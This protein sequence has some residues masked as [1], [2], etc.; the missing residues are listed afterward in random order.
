MGP[1][2]A[3]II[4]GV[5]DTP[6]WTTSLMLAV[7]HAALALVF[8]IY[9]LILVTEAG[10]NA[11]DAEQVVTASILAMAAGTLLQALGWRQMGSGYLAVQ[12]NN[13]IYLP[14][15]ILAVHAGGLDTAF[16]MTIFAGAAA[17][18]FSRAIKHLRPFFPAEVCGVGVLMLGISM[19][20][21][22]SARFSG[23]TETGTFDAGV[24]AV[25]S[26]TF[27]LMVALSVWPKGRV[28]LYSAIIGLCSGYAASIAFGLTSM[29][30][31]AGIMDRGLLA[32]PR[33]QE[34]TP[35]FSPILAVPFLLTAMVSTLDSMA[36]L[37]TCQKINHPAQSRPDMGNIGQGILADGCGTI[38]AGLFGT[39]GTGVSSAHIALTSATGA[40]SRTIGIWTSATLLATAFVPPVAK[41]LAR[42]PDPVIGAVMAYASAFLITSGME[43]IVSRILDVRR[44]FMVGCSVIVG[45]SSL[46]SGAHATGI[47]EWAASIVSSPFA[48]ASLCAVLL[49]SLF[50][51]GTSQRASL[52]IGASTESIGPLLRFLDAQCAAWGIRRQVFFQL[53]ACAT[54][55]VELLILMQSAEGPVNIEARSEEHGLELAIAYAGAPL[56]LEPGSPDPEEFLSSKAAAARLAGALV[57]QYADGVSI[58]SRQGRQRIK[59]HFEP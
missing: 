5:S 50:R 1:K 38:C 12:I 58:E 16:G 14:V 30:E 18:L 57:R 43:L 25:A 22:G 27:V 36:G 10:G 42:I 41:L 24:F 59:L 20:G 3:N 40:T 9:P 54:E 29:S 44:I 37:I 56:P 15:S 55:V 39:L 8:I 35:A 53:Q 23:Y 17:L 48:L 6:P 52:S 32:M 2:P 7:Q 49:N 21:P 46:T 45:L 34:H 11:A 31:L 47:P 13:P 33:M 26:I 28:R 19:A 4:Y 51:I